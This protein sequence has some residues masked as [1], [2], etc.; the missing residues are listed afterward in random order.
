MWNCGLSVSVRMGAGL[1]CAPLLSHVH[2]T[3][4]D[5]ILYWSPASDNKHPWDT[6]THL[7]ALTDFLEDPEGAKEFGSLCHGK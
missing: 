6:Y 3:M 1:T 4:A 7:Q 2:E 5:T